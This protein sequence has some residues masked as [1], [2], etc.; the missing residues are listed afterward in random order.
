MATYW[1]TL[2]ADSPTVLLKM[3]EASGSLIDT[4]VGNDAVVSGAA[5]TYHAAGPDATGIPYAV[6]F[7]NTTL[8]TITDSAD[9]DLL[10]GPFSIEFWLKKGASGGTQQPVRKG[11][12]STT[13]GYDCYLSG[14][15]FRLTNGALTSNIRQ[16]TADTDLGWHH[17]VF[18]R[19]S[20]LSGKVWRDKVDVTTNSNT[21]S[22]LDNNNNLI[23]GNDFAGSM[24]GFAV[25]KSQLSSTQVAAHYDARGNAAAGAV[26]PGILAGMRQAVAQAAVW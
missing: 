24:A 26:P 4:Q 1:E 16:T 21:L 3:D 15:L 12:N 9:L 14:N 5:M 23:L 25:Y 7:A 22:F 17:W 6:T 8:A 11:D 10:D 2:I 13:P 19:A 20:G 18:T